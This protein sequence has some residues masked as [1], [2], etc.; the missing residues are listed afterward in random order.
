M[1]SGFTSPLWPFIAQTERIPKVVVFLSGTSVLFLW[2]ARA[3]WLVHTDLVWAVGAALLL[4]SCSLAGV[5]QYRR[6]RRS[7]RAILRLFQMSAWPL[8][9]SF[10][11]LALSLGSLTGSIRFYAAHWPVIVSI[12]VGLL[13]VLSGSYV[14]YWRVFRI[15]YQVFSSYLAA[16]SIPADRLHGILS[17]GQSTRVASRLPVFVGVSVPLFAIVSFA[18]SHALHRDMRETLGFCIFFLLANF[19]MAVLIARRWL[20]WRHLGGS[21]LIVVD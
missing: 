19:F 11:A 1:E 15:Q 20:Q 16:G 10:L 14:A 8:A 6:N 7:L 4:I 2:M 9:L 3:K 12:F 18:L 21:D 5:W 17:S 13:L